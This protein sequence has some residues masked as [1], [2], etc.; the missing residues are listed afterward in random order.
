MEDPYYNVK[1]TLIEL[2]QL[3]AEKRA[4]WFQHILL[5]GTTLLGILVSLHTNSSSNLYVRL[6]FALSIVQLALGLLL[7]G[8]LL[9]SFQEAIARTRQ[10]YLEKAKLAVRENKQPDGA[11]APPKKIYIIA[12]KAAYICLASSFLF[13]T[14]YVVLYSFLS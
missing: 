14:L 5:V 6:C 4:Q 10:D 8:M 2:A 9:Y 11:S 3:L 1:K 13:L 7:S 12:E